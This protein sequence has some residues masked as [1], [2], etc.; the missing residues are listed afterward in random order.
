MKVSR[1][2]FWMYYLHYVRDLYVCE[3]D[4]YLTVELI[5]EE[6]QAFEAEMRDSLMAAT[7][8]GVSKAAKPQ[9]VRV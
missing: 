6:A 4:C 5:T 8:T 2:I 9:V 7:K 3:D 1:V